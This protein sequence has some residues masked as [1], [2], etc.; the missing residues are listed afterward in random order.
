M[1][2]SALLLISGAG[3]GSLGFSQ[4][5]PSNGILGFLHRF[6][7]GAEADNFNL[8]LLEERFSKPKLKSYVVS[9]A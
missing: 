5:M 1:Y 9:D 7:R 6:L 2:S 8:D 4:I 3:L